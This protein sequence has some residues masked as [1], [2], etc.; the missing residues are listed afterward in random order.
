DHRAFAQRMHAEGRTEWRRLAPPPPAM[1][2][3][4][5]WLP[6]V[7]DRRPR[8]RPAV[9]IR[10]DSLQVAP[11]PTPIWAR[12]AAVAVVMA[13][14]LAV[15]LGYHP[16]R[17][18]VRAGAPID[19]MRDIRVTGAQP[20]PQPHGAGGRFLLLWVRTSRP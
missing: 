10:R 20:Q 16:P 4:P 3:R 7:T 15:L 12:A 11:R 17:A 6:A 5:A 19:V 8:P 14:A 1:G 18:V 2:E 9:A 13:T